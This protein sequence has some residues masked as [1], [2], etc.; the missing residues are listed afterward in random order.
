MLKEGIERADILQYRFFQNNRTVRDDPIISR[1]VLLEQQKKHAE[2][3]HL[4]G[5]ENVRNDN[6]ELSLSDEYSNCNMEIQHSLQLNM[7]MKS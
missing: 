2:S 5:I 6:D 4:V 3:P 1:N 7:M